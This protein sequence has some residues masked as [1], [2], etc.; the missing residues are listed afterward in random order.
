VR[1]D[2]SALYACLLS[3]YRCLIGRH[4]AL[5]DA[6]PLHDA[7]RARHLR[8][9]RLAAEDGAAWADRLHL[10]WPDALRVPQ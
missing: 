2:L 4:Q 5:A 10:P 7:R 1:E 9:A 6:W 3:D 8:H